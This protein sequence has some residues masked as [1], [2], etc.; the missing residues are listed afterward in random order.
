MPPEAT[1]QSHGWPVEVLH[2]SDMHDHIIK[3]TM[4]HLLQAMVDSPGH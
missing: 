3:G 4:I 1:P 2:E